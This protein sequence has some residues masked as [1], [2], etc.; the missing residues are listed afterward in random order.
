MSESGDTGFWSRF[1]RRFRD[2]T[3]GF[4]GSHERYRGFER[5]QGSFQEVLEEFSEGFRGLARGF[6]GF[7]MRYRR[8][9]GVPGSFLWNQSF[10]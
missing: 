5:L 3:G 6:G 9:D 8:F 10:R 1:Q 4:I 7:Q 2:V